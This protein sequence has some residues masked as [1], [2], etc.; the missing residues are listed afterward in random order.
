M[1]SNTSWRNLI[2]PE[3]A[4]AQREVIDAGGPT[5]SV[6]GASNSILKF[7]R[8]DDIDSSDGFVTVRFT[9]AAEPYPV[10]NTVDTIS[11]SAAADDG[12]QIRLI[13]TRIVGGSGEDV[14]FE[15]VRQVVTLD[16][17]NKV[18]LPTPMARISR[19][20]VVGSQDAVGDVYVYIDTAITNGV[21]NDLTQVAAQVEADTNSSFSTLLTVADGNYL[22]VDQIG[23]GSLRQGNGNIDFRFETRSPGSVFRSRFEFGASNQSGVSDIKL[24]EPIIVAPNSDIRIRA[25]VTSNNTPAYAY[26]GAMFAK[27]RS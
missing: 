18:T 11:S 15:R 10:A 17:R 25:A 12:V 19:A 5:T 22:F 8:Q 7:G 9:K 4:Q 16:G 6:A 1:G 3:M 20:Y 13:G 14:R 23:G 27:V 26:F 21:P 2:S 24:S